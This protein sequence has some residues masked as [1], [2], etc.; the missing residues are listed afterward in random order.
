MVRLVAMRYV[1]TSRVRLKHESS[2]QDLGHGHTHLGF[3]DAVT[4][5]RTRLPGNGYPT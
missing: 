5:E 4:Q 3:P 2:V 1:V